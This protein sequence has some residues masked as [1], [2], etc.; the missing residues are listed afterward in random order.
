LITGI[1]LDT[2][3]DKGYLT[4]FFTRRALRILPLY[5]ACLAVVFAAMQAGLL[6]ESSASETYYWFY[7]QNWLRFDDSNRIRI[8]AHFWS[9]AIEEQFYLVWPFLI[10]VLS[11]R[12][13]PVLCAT[14]VVVAAALR[15]GL[16]CG[17][18]VDAQVTSFLTVTRMDT[19]AFGALIAVIVR[20]PRG[21]LFLEHAWKFLCGGAMAAVLL[22]V[23]AAGRFS[24]KDEITVF[25]GYS[26]VTILCGGLVIACFASHEDGRFRKVMRNRAL[27]WIGRV[28]YGAY[29]FHWPIMV[30]LGKVWF[31]K[32]HLGFWPN[33][34]LWWL[35]S[36]SATFICAAISF[37][38]FEKPFLALKERFRSPNAPAGAGSA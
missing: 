6:M 27:R 5:Y 9:L 21:I 14:M 13:I 7:L 20:T 24:A 23:L 33:Q 11:K 32:K 12:G 35:A 19:L 8:L 31:I 26:A 2:K 1:L 3:H 25:F 38:F 34:V 28:S 15:V 18:V 22:L 37:L 36:F 17:E 30:L 4:R 29:V 10:L 16:A